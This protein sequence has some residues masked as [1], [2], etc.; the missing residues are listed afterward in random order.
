[1]NTNR[2]IDST[3]SSLDFSLNGRSDFFLTTS[4]GY[5]SALLFFLM[6]QLDVSVNCLYIKS[7]LAINGIGD[8][9]DYITNKF[10][11]NLEIIDRSE[12]LDNQ[13]KGKE[14]LDLELDFRKKLCR[15]LKRRPLLQFI[16]ENK[17]KIWI[18]GIRKDQ[19]ESRK[20][21]QY[22]EVTDLSVIKIS[23]LFAWTRDDVKNLIKQNNLKVN[24]DHLDLCKLNE[25]K[26]CGLH[27]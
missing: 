22:L 11:I 25:S 7:K 2:L 15:E 9:M 6:S 21:I 4:F 26:E 24:P 12:W 20:K 5:Q 13:L 1:M 17:Y 18:S 3:L 10:D 14:F 19:S 27:F 16:E 23:P 8:Q